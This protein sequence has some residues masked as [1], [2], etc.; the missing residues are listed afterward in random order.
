M[1]IAVT[2]TDADLHTAIRAARLDSK[3]L[4]AVIR[5]VKHDGNPNVIQMR[6]AQ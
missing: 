6:R 4:Q 2:L 5:L 1:R 3:D